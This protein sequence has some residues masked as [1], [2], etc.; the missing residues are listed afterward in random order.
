MNIKLKIWKILIFDI[1]KFFSVQ[2]KNRLVKEFFVG[3]R[4]NIVRTF[5]YFFELVNNYFQ[6]S[7][8]FLSWLDRIFLLVCLLET[9]EKAIF[10]RGPRPT[11]RTNLLRAVCRLTRRASSSGARRTT[12]TGWKS[13]YSPGELYDWSTSPWTDIQVLN[14]RLE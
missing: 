8:E 13:D 1:W 11:F 9:G 5:E 4:K 7:V 6:V 14:L 10:S 2:I 3:F 12:L